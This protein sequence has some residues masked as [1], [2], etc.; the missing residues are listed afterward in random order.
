M[1]VHKVK[2]TQGEAPDGLDDNWE[3]NVEPVGEWRTKLAFIRD[4]DEIVLTS[5]Q[6][7]PS[8]QVA[9]SGG[10]NKKTSSPACPAASISLKSSLDRR[11]TQVTMTKTA[12]CFRITTCPPTLL[13]Q[14]RAE[15]C[16]AG[17]LGACLTLVRFACRRSASCCA[18]HWV[19]MR[20]QSKR[21]RFRVMATKRKSC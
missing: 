21:W 11:W 18:Q 9:A 17:A 12:C 19:R 10:L 1:V 16:A 7:L 8:W 4:Q 15:P 13:P 2:V 6:V 5:L 14:F 20:R 3:L